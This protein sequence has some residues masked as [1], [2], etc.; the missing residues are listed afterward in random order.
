[1]SILHPESGASST[2]PKDKTHSKLMIALT[3]GVLV[4]GYMT[5][6]RMASSSSST[7]AAAPDLTGSATMPNAGTGAV[8]VS[9]IEGQ[10]AQLSQGFGDFQNQEAADIGS[11]NN[12]QAQQQGLLSTLLD[13]SNQLSQSIAGLQAQA[14]NTGAPVNLAADAIAAM[15]ANGEH[16]VDSVNEGA[17]TLYLTNKGGVYTAGGA[18]VQ[19]QGSYLGYAASTANPAAEIAGHGDFSSGHIHLGPNGAYTETNNLGENYTFSNK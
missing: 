18:Q 1:M 4:I 10:I 14:P 8:D 11:L 9:G 15:K 13:S 5:Y 7:S 17:G 12:A 16:I 19:G 2:G 6:R 3:V